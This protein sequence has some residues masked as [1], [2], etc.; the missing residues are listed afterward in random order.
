MSLRRKGVFFRKKE[1]QK[2]GRMKSM[3]NIFKGGMHSLP[4]GEKGKKKEDQGGE[5]DK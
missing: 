3:H 4:W 1:E 5:E 2:I